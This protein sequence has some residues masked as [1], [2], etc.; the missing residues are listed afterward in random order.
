MGE[1]FQQP[2]EREFM[3]YRNL[4]LCFIA[5]LFTLSSISNASGWGTGGVVQT[6]L[7]G[8]ETANVVVVQP[9]GKV[10]AAGQSDNDMVVVR[11]NANG[12]LDNSFGTGGVAKVQYPLG[13]SIAND[14]EVL[15]DGKILIVGTT[16]NSSTTDVALV[17]LNSNGS[18]DPSFAGGGKIRTDYKGANN[19]GYQLLIGAAGEIFVLEGKGAPS[20]HRY[21]SN[22]SLDTN[23]DGD[24]FRDLSAHGNSADTITAAYGFAFDDSWYDTIFNYTELGVWTGSTSKVYSGTYSY[25]NGSQSD[26]IT[27]THSFVVIQGQGES[28]R[29][30][31]FSKDISVSSLGDKAFF[32]SYGNWYP[33]RG[34]NSIYDVGFYI[35]DTF[36][37]LK[38]IRDRTNTFL[39]DLDDFKGVVEWMPDNSL[40]VSCG[41]TLSKVNSSGSKITSFGVGGDIETNVFTS[42]LAVYGS[43]RVVQLSTSSNDFYLAV[44]NADGSPFINTPPSVTSSTTVSG[45]VQV[46]LEYIITATNDPTSYSAADLPQGLSLDTS[47]G[48]PKI[49]GTPSESG[50]FIVTISATNSGGTGDAQVTF[51]IANTSQTITFNN[52]GAQVL[53]ALPFPADAISSSGLPVTVAVESGPVTVIDNT[54]Y[55]TGVGLAVLTA[56]QAGSDDYEAADDVSVTFSIVYTG[57]AP[58][59]LTNPSNASSTAGASAVFAV[60]A[61]GPQPYLY[62]WLKNGEEL[63]GQTSSVL[64]LNGVGYFD[65]ADYSC[66]VSNSFGDTLSANASL[67]VTADPNGPD[68]DSDGISDPVEAYLAPFGFD[69]DV[70]SSAAWA[71]LRA[72]VSEQEL[73]DGY[74]AD[75]MRDLALGSPVI[76]RA[77]NGDFNLKMN[78]LTSDDLET[79]DVNTLQAEDVGVD[80]G[81]LDVKLNPVNPDIQFFK[82]TAE[83]N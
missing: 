54:V 9:D 74:T 46:P 75:Q 67:N 14:L 76:Q 27:E 70:D 69:P 43:S 55:L 47:S 24:G 7:G 5:C 25:S 17:R 61:S 11:Y 32:F 8:V 35:N 63:E 20:I 2:K 30:Q 82:I 36:H 31:Y 42:D 50:T 38:T 12:T 18:L 1:I 81:S 72:M 10:L 22:G 83:T 60:S 80:S 3:K 45:E 16:Y 57:V 15:S 65:E 13:W 48:A 64:I 73:G 21:K 51:E 4:I 71:R 39:Y 33:S 44:Y 77:E 78:L 23:F 66:R 49:V 68:S 56:S 19:E 34:Y 53:G 6:D 37:A 52:P 29:L 62:Q 28:H 40:Y 41:T 26:A 58:S 79:W 59:M